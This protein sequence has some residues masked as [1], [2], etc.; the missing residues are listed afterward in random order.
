M[1]FT[2]FILSASLALAGAPAMADR[3]DRDDI[4]E[5]QILLSHLGYD[6]AG[7]DGIPGPDLAAAI[8]AFETDQGLPPSGR[9]TAQ[10]N[11]RLHDVV[12]EQPRRTLQ[13]GPSVVPRIGHWQRFPWPSRMGGL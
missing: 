11:H 9:A 13:A 1:R 6:P 7:I 12:A 2:A 10:L 5:I 4:V 3:V 8:R